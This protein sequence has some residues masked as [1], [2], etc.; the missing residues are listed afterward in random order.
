MQAN[1]RQTSRKLELESVND[2]RFIQIKVS[3]KGGQLR[4]LIEREKLKFKPGCAFFEFKNKKEDIDEKKE[5]ILMEKVLSHPLLYNNDIIAILTENR[6][7]VY[8]PC[9]SLHNWST[10]SRY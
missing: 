8:R 10:R 3:S 2:N 5:V 4:Q 9:S 6:K 1:P 7:D